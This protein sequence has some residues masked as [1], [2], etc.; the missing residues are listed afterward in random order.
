MS[1]KQYLL[2]ESKKIDLGSDIDWENSPMKVATLLKKMYPSDIK[3]AIKK[4]DN[5]FSNVTRKRL[6][7]G[8]KYY[9]MSFDP[10]LFMHKHKIVE[11]LKK[12]Y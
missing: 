4:I 1:F 2:D 7:P 12:K 8:D 6:Y 5:F 9:K 11:L 10:G 3:S